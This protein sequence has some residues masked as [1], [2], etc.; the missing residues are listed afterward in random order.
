MIGLDIRN[1]L[2]RPELSINVMFFK[3][4]KW[5]EGGKWKRFLDIYDDIAKKQFEMSKVGNTTY[6]DTQIHIRGNPSKPSLI[7]FH[8]IATNSLMFGD[9]LIPEL[10]KDYYCVAIDTIGDMGR[11]LP[12]DSDPS[13]G[14]KNEQE[15]ADWALQV[16]D[17]LDLS[18][19]KVNIVGY[20]LGAFIAS[21]VARYY[22]SRVAR[23]VFMAPAGV[24]SPVRKLWLAQAILFTV[25]T[26][27]TPSGKIADRLQ[28][29][30]FGSMV[31]DVDNLK[32]LQYPELRRA[33]DV[34]GGPQVQVQP[35]VLDVV[36]LTKMTRENPTLLILGQQESVINAAVAVENAKMSN[37]KVKLF[38]NA[39]HMFF[40]EVPKKIVIDEVKNF[41]SNAE[42]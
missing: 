19:N 4:S 10:S 2:Q 7:F 21:C 9:W 5:H 31:A 30:F 18:Q 14:P 37:M 12:R 42:E 39:G 32:N 6:G 36:T 24:V 11:S 13:N 23:L 16:F 29:W 27:I 35:D 3:T 20:S 15:M 28:T 1:C 34:L 8:G 38:D 41:L 22:P 26:S 25:L 40:C 33:T 17:T